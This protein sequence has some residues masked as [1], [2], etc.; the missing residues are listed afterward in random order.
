MADEKITALPELAA[1]PADDDLLAVVDVSETPDLTK[2]ITVSNLLA[3]AV[4][5][6]V[7]KIIT[8]T[9][10]YDAST[11]DVA[12]TGVGFQPSAIIGIGS[13][14][15][16]WVC[17]GFGDGTNKHYFNHYQNRDPLGN[18]NYFMLCGDPW[19]G[20]QYANIDSMDADGFTLAWTNNSSVS[21]TYTATLLF[22][23]LK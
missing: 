16:Y 5:S 6:G 20:F 18:T 8:A 23:C 1:T 22:L 13:N 11:G 14:A 10:V 15:N 12:Y 3:G 21:S 9:R 2:K 17:I 4:A 19:S 7:G